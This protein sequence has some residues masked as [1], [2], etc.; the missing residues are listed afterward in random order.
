MGEDSPIT[1]E[2][3]HRSFIGIAAVVV[4][5]VVSSLLLV[6]SFWYVWPLLLVLALVLIAFLTA[7]KKT[8]RCPSC[9]R[10][11]QISVL[12]D[13]LAFHGLER[14]ADGRFY[15]WKM[16]RCPRCSTR[17]RSFPVDEKGAPPWD[18]GDHPDR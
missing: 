6:T 7:S 15:E 9:G 17:S 13:F 16:L 14:R 8:W 18:G 5:I 12:Q 4:L 1:R 3:I 2:E 11:Y 10:S